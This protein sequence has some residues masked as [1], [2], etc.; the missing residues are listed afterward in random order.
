VI[1]NDVVYVKTFQKM[2]NYPQIVK[3]IHDEFNIAGERLL[4]ESLEILKKSETV[5][6]DKAHRLNEA[7]FVNNPL[8]KQAA[9]IEEETRSA[10][11]IANLVMEYKLKYPNNKFISQDDVEKICKK[12][13]L[14]FG[15]AEQYIGFVPAKNLS[16]IEVFKK[17]S[18]V[19]DRHHISD[20]V[21]SYSSQSELHKKFEQKLKSMDY[22]ISDSLLRTNHSGSLKDYLSWS[23]IKEIV[24]INSFK[25]VKISAFD[26][27]A[28]KKDMISKE[29]HSKLKSLFAT[30]FSV[31]PD[32][33][34]LYPVQMGY[35]I[36]TAWGDEAS[37]PLVANEQ[38]N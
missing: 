31:V 13:N 32:P 18:R 8:L 24:H 29:K 37:D 10:S 14:V 1:V 4:Q 23:F 19:E 38:M 16:D 25:S 5:D 22:K 3:D 34:V 6:L 2:N 28:P 35:I 11:Y 20:V 9:K 26:I 33:V 17:N 12:Y 21:F 27:V 7:G 30:K 15:N 36:V